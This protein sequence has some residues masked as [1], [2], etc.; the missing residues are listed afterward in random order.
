MNKLFRDAVHKNEIDK[1]KCLLTNQEVD[2]N[3]TDS[4]GSTA[5]SIACFDGFNEIVKFLLMDPRVQVNKP[6]KYGC[7]CLYFACKEN[8][9]ETTKLLLTIPSLDVRLSTNEGMLPFLISCY[10]SHCE[11]VQ[12]FLEKKIN[13]LHEYEVLLGQFVLYC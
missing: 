13:E 1:V 7:S 4:N 11:I 12:V 10:Y 9:I 8:R 3:S 2:I 5:L 6:N